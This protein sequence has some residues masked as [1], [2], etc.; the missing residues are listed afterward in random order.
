MFHL[1]FQS[2]KSSVQHIRL[3]PLNH[4]LLYCGQI[5]LFSS[6]LSN[7]KDVF[8]QDV[9]GSNQSMRIWHHKKKQKKKKMKMEMRRDDDS[10]YDDDG[11]VKKQPTLV[12]LCGTAGEM[13]YEM[14]DHFLISFY[15]CLI[16]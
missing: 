13:G 14:V 6:S 12:L 9:D 16:F 1:I 2:I 4:Q 7:Y 15:H 3:S 11:K 5:H 10:K 8:I